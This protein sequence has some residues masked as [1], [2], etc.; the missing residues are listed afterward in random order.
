MVTQELYAGIA[1]RYDRFHG[2]FGQ[3]DLSVA[4][5]F[6]QLFAEHQME[7]VLDCACGT[8]HHLPLFHSLGCEVV[9]SDI[10]EAMLAQAERNLA[11]AG[12]EVPLHQADYRELPRHFDREFDAVTCLSSSILHMPTEAEALRAFESMRS[13]LRDGGIL[14]LTQ[15][16]TDKQWQERPRF[17]LAVNERDFTRLFVIDYV[18]EGARYNILDI[19]HAEA[20][21]N[22]EVWSVEYSRIYLKDNQER[23][24]KTSGFEMIDFYGSYR[25]EPYDKET[26]NRLITVAQK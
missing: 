13:V 5:F 10:S 3:H 9:G 11:Q 26:S 18:G 21:R 2:A 12:L 24:L 16:T 1:A 15:G 20:E 25:R 19:H 23:L 17:I 8:G 14:V 7:S 4:E 22:F 6:R